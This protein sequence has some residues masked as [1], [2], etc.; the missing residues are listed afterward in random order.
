MDC[1]WLREGLKT[2]AQEQLQ[3]GSRAWGT[4][5]TYLRAGSIFSR[6][7]NE[8]AGQLEPAEMSRE[9]FLDFVAWV[10]DEDTTPTDLH[11][12]NAL[13]RLLNDLK[14]NDIVPELPEAV[15]LRRGENAI[16]KTRNPKP[17]PADILEAIDRLI[18]D[19]SAIPRAERLILRLFRAVGP[20]ATEALTL[21]HDAVTCTERGYTLQYFQSKIQDWRKV[22]LPPKLG[23][24]LVAQKQW[25]ADTYGAACRW[26]FPYA[27]PRP[28]T[29]TVVHPDGPSPWPFA[30]YSHFIWKLYQEH[31]ITCSAVTGETLTGAQLHRFR[32]SI[33]TGLLNESWSQYEV[34]TFLGHKSPTMMQAYAEIND[35]KLRDKYLEFINKSVDIDGRNVEPPDN[36]T[37]DVERLRD[38]FIRSTLPNGFCTL[39]EKQKC[40]FLPSPC[41]SCTF[42]RTTRT[43]LPVHIRQRD[44]AIRE[45]DIAEADGRQ[46]AAEAHAS[47]VTRLD[48][49][50]DGL[51]QV[52][53]DEEDCGDD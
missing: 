36:A 29:N 31:G 22:P 6:Y 1:R 12:V 30:R 33:A 39:P 53:D 42:F 10:R 14:I 23:Q 21:P 52:P 41:L 7:L 32:H 26:M 35:D 25:V 40:E 16:P 8:E 20:R 4:I 43:F 34:Q 9:I 51:N 13:A 3:S 19:E 49:I 5:R 44:E 15:F 24:D 2:L 18:A 47:V 50:I 46:R 28:R 11:A 48:T 37:V 27:G 45:L 38:R 17:F